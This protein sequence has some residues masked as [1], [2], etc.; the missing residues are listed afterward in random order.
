M[1]KMRTPFSHI[2]KL[3]AL[4]GVFL[5]TTLAFCDN[6]DN[7]EF[8]AR[9]HARIFRKAEIDS[10][11][12]VAVARGDWNLALHLCATKSV[13]HKGKLDTLLLDMAY[14]ALRC[15]EFDI[16]ASCIDRSTARTQHVVQQNYMRALFEAYSGN[17]QGA[18]HIAETS[19]ESAKTSAESTYALVCYGI[20]ATMA[21]DFESSFS[22]LR[23]AENLESHGNGVPRFT[24]LIEDTKQSHEKTLTLRQHSGAPCVLTR[25]VPLLYF[26]DGTSMRGGEVFIEQIAQIFGSPLFLPGIER[27]GKIALPTWGGVNLPAEIN[28]EL[29]F[30]LENGTRDSLLLF[31][32]G[33]A[34]PSG[35]GAQFSA[36]KT[37]LDTAAMFLWAESLANENAAHASEVLRIFATT[38]LAAMLV[39]ANRWQ[40]GLSYCDNLTALYPNLTQV[41]MWR[42]AFSMYLGALDSA[43]AIFERA[44]EGDT[45]NFGARY[46]AGVA[47]YL[48]GKYYRAEHHFKAAVAANAN[49]APAYL[50]LGILEMRI[51]GDFDAASG[52]FERYLK[53]TNFLAYEVQKWRE[54][55]NR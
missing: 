50:A 28:V 40:A 30:C 10:Q 29:M 8:I 52:Y 39:D 26:D 51:F 7:L 34:T 19:L 24:M 45:L 42:G 47:C 37:D 12:Q 41:A 14:F 3:C 49:F 1:G 32:H 16:A 44:V 25:L 6:F 35:F 43:E 15:N 11:L 31:T 36:A 53:L 27:A 5:F 48:N 13:M 21:G 20:I 54:E 9:E 18:E 2:Q 4:A 38:K 23:A 33:N 55:M 46:N 22:H 17:L